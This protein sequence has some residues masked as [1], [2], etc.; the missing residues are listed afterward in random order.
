MSCPTM[1][2]AEVISSRSEWGRGDVHGDDH[3]AADLSRNVDRQIVRYAPSTSRRPSISTG[4]R[5]RD[6]H[7]RAH[8]PE[9]LP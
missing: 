3:L 2:S 4:P 6:G 1:L 8:R 7:A 5:R 9:R